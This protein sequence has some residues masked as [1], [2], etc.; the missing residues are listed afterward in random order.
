MN[1]NKLKASEEETTP[2]EVDELKK[3]LSSDEV[4]E[5][6]GLETFMQLAKWFFNPLKMRT[7]TIIS[8][9]LI[10]ITLI[11]GIYRNEWLPFVVIVS[12][13]I[14]RK[15]Y[16]LLYE[17]KLVKVLKEYNEAKDFDNYLRSLE[18][19]EDEENGFDDEDCFNEY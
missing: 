8:L 2:E 16:L 10:A 11:L 7:T 5:L 9:I 19:M 6:E 17:W 13:T 15:S 14:L 12:T 1:L 4:K 3:V 18:A